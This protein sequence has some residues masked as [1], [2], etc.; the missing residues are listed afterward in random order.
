MYLLNDKHSKYEYII[1]TRVKG[2]MP[3]LKGKA[4]QS[5]YEICKDLEDI[6]KRH[7]RYNMTYYI[8]NDFFKNEY[9]KSNADFYYKILKREVNDWEET[10]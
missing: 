4:K 3:Y 8:D 5:Y 10:A 6:A 7:D 2:A 9:D 1:Y